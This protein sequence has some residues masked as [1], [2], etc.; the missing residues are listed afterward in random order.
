MTFFFLVD[1]IL[2]MYLADKKI[3]HFFLPLTL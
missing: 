3:A 1:Y 2:R